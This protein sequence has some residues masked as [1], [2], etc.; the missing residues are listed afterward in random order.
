[1]LR[2]VRR[3]ENFQRSNADDKLELPPAGGDD[4]WIGDLDRRTLFTYLFFSTC[5]GAV[6]VVRGGHVRGVEVEM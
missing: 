6:P 2:H 3:Y 4:R 5:D 1:M